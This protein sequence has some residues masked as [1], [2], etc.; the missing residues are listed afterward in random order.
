MPTV[1]RRLAGKGDPTCIPGRK[2]RNKA[3]KNDKRSNCIEIMFGSLKELATRR[4]PLRSL[5]KGL[6]SA[7]ALA[8]TV[9][10]WL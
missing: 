5:P 2:I 10:F 9:I 3:V 1:Q 4:N 7:V 8:A 6:F